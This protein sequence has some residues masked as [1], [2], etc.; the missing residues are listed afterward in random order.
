MQQTSK[1][2]FNAAAIFNLYSAAI[3]IL[4]AEQAPVSIMISWHKSQ[5]L[6]SGTLTCNY[7]LARSINI[8]ASHPNT[9]IFLDGLF[10]ST[11]SAT[12][13]DEDII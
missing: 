8:C 1:N 9:K 12:G 13:P 3:F 4:S 7:R 11:F 5:T 2:E 6:D 10:D